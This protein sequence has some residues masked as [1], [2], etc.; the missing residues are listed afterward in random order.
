MKEGCYVLKYHRERCILNGGIWKQRRT[1]E[2]SGGD[3]G[4]PVSMHETRKNALMTRGGNIRS[5]YPRQ[6][7][8]GRAQ[9]VDDGQL[10]NRFSFL[11]RVA[12]LLVSLL[13]AEFEDSWRM[14]TK[15]TDKTCCTD[16]DDFRPIFW[17]SKTIGA[18]RCWNTLFIR[19]TS[20][21]KSR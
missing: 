4:V 21:E 7:L 15:S 3:N 19:S 13:D 2:T 12:A 20:H 6:K 1:A 11:V 16:I 5:I 17:G 10:S 14:G 18:D 8:N 9:S